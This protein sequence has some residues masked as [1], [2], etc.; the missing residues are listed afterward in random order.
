LRL[1]FGSVREEHAA[2]ALVLLLDVLYDHAIAQRLEI[3]VNLQKL[4]G[5]RLVRLSLSKPGTLSNRVPA[6][7][8]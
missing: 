7:K 3:H 5:I 4:N 1:L 2:G 6:T 8:S